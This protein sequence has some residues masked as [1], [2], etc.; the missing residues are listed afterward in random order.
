[1]IVI[2]L[3]VLLLLAADSLSDNPCFD[4][5]AI[6]LLLSIAIGATA[7][8]VAAGHMVDRGR[9]VRA[10]PRVALGLLVSLVV[11]A[12]ALVAAEFATRWIYR[13]ITT[14]SDDRG[15]FSRRW[16]RSG[17]VTLNRHGFRER[18][19]A[20]IKPAGTIRIAVVGDS[21]VFGNGIPAER[22]FSTLLQHSLPSGFEVLNFGVPGNNTRE[23][24]ETLRR[25]LAFMPDVVLLQWFVNDVEAETRS[26]PIHTTLVPSARLHKRLRESS[27]LYGFL[28]TWWTRRQASGSSGSS[29]AKYM[30]SRY[31]DPQADAVRVN[32]EAMRS[33]ASQARNAGADLGIV[34]F[35]DT[36]YDLGTDYPF[37]FLHTR[38]LEFCAVER[39]TC[40]DLRPAFAAV[41]RRQSLWANQLDSHPSAIA[42]TLA[43][44]KILQV[45]RSSWLDHATRKP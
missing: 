21:F 30:Q 27:A 1:M 3:A 6:A 2:G 40:L 10:A 13:D 24:V 25:A 11:T 31:G 43:A 17:A 38:V 34:L 22:R 20:D 19:V 16:L 29:Y 44:A 33:L 41:K 9:L 14:T 35:P 7:L 37:A 23:Q 42:N 45:F 36:G 28:D 32:R 5:D 26:R 18:D 12:V 15:Y 39:V 8:V 4:P